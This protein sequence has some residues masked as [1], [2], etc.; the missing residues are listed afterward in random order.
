MNMLSL[1]SRSLAV[2]ATRLAAW[3]VLITLPQCIAAQ[4]TA[5]SI[6]GTLMDPAGAVVPDATV[7]LHNQ[8]R[9]TSMQSKSDG[10]GR[11]VF[12]IV[13]PGKYSITAEAVGFK[14]L[15]RANVI[16]NANTGLALGNLTFELGTN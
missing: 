16:L 5:G 14:K 15:E 10:G 3:L 4:T 7:I 11:F 13:Q 1:Y 2:A 8:D 6:T 9:N 12:P